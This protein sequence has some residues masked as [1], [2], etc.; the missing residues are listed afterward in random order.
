M[1][2][3]TRLVYLISFLLGINLTAQATHLRAGEITVKRKNCSNTFTITIHVLVKAS[4]TAVHFSESNGGVLNFGDGSPI[5]HPTM[6]TDPNIIGVDAD[7]FLIGEVKVDVDHVFPGQGTYIISYYEQNRNEGILNMDNSVGTPFFIQTQIKIN[8]FLGCDNTPVL[9][10]PPIDQACTHVKWFHNPGAYDPDG[11]SLSY[12]L[13]VPK[14]GATYDNDGLEVSAQDVSGYLDPNSIAFYNGAASPPDPYNQANEASD[15]PP[16]FKIDPLYGTITWDSP[17]EAGEYNIAFLIKEWRKDINGKWRLLG[18][19]ERDMQIIVKSCTNL[20]PLLQ[21]PPNICVQAGTLVTEDIYATDPD[22]SPTGGGRNKGDSV[23]IE[24]FSNIFQKGAISNPL[25]TYTPGPAVWQP[26]FSPTDQAH[27]QFNWQTVCDHVKEQPYEITVKATDNGGPPLATYGA[28]TITVVAPAPQWNS[29]TPVGRSAELSWKN[30]TCS[31]TASGMQIYRR[32]DSAPFTPSPCQTGLPDSLGYTLIGQVPIGTTNYN[33]QNLAAGAR[34]C[35]RLVA[36]F[37]DGSESV[38]S[39]EICIPPFLADAPVVTNVTIDVTD[40]QNGRVTVKWRSPFE[41]DKNLFPAPYSFEVK[42]ADGT[43][44]IA[45]Y[46]NVSKLLYPGTLFDSTLVDDYKLNT[47]ANSYHYWVVAKASNG[48]IID[49]SATAST[50]RLDLV[51]QFKQILLQW[52]AVVPWSNNDQLLPNPRH[53]IYRGVNSASEVISDLT[54]IDSVDVAK[55]FA[56]LDSGQYNSTPLVQTSNYCYGVMTRG[57]YGNPKIKAPLNNFSQIICSKPDTLGKPCKLSIV[58]KAYDCNPDLNSV[59]KFCPDDGNIG[60]G[61]SSLPPNVI[62]WKKPSD[63]GCNSSIVGYNIYASS[64][65]DQSF[66]VIAK[67]VADTFFI[68]N[69]LISHA[70]CYKISAVNA[71]GKESDLSDSFCFENC[72]YYELPNVFTPN[73]DGCNDLFSAYNKRKYGDPDEGF[74]CNNAGTPDA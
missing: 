13:Y 71:A 40:T 69:N 42:R 56:Y 41:A 37:P 58:A 2:K 39:D 66:T 53:L 60:L 68:H 52:S 61:D 21:V 8:D 22:G 35:Y 44:G 46:V 36:I 17:G 24:L 57:S 27:V 34:Y 14:Q 74:P 28:F 1:G 19:V 25:A 18:T 15:G 11:D 3:I 7:G 67:V 50:V 47:A 10:V 64:G 4:G 23:K 33:D 73:G 48:Q 72:P 38:A 45:G 9:L 30:Y 20:R 55:G 54:L 65:S 63:S 29:I 31:S 43:S 26:T 49:S 6:V 51:P 59:N 5:F 62:T 32:V 12:Q 70:W 16:T